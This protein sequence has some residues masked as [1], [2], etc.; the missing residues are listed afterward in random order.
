LIQQRPDLVHILGAD[1]SAGAADEA[2]QSAD[3]WLAMN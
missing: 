3:R 1:F 2:V